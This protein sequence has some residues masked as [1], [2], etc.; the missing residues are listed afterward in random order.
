MRIGKFE[1]QAQNEL[2]FG[3][4]YLTPDAG[5]GINTI[6]PDKINLP[7]RQKILHTANLKSDRE[8]HMPANLPGFGSAPTENITYKHGEMPCTS[9]DKETQSALLNGIVPHGFKV[10]L[11][12]SAFTLC[13]VSPGL[14]EM[15]GY[16]PEGHT[17]LLQACKG[18]LAAL[19]V[20][21]DI[22]QVSNAWQE[23]G[24]AAAKYTCEYRLYCKNG[25]TLWVRESG[26]KSMDEQG[27]PVVS[28]VLVGINKYKNTQMQLDYERERS[29]IVLASSAE[30]IYEYQ[31]ENDHMVFY[32]SNLV[33]DEYELVCKHVPNWLE[34]LEQ[35]NIIH[36]DDIPAVRKFFTQSSYHTVEARF[37]NVR[38]TGEEYVWCLIHGTAVYGNG[39]LTKVIGDITNSSQARVRREDQEELREIFYDALSQ[40]YEN[41]CRINTITDTY[42]LYSSDGKPFRNVPNSGNYSTE[43]GYFIGKN[44]YEPDRPAYHRDM[45]IAS[46]MAVLDAGHPEADFSYRSLEADGSVRWKN[47]R[48]TYFHDNR[49]TILLTV[50]DVH[51]IRV[52][53]EREEYRLSALLRESCDY[54]ME[55]NLENGTCRQYMP[56]EQNRY[57]LPDHT[58]YAEFLHNYADHYVLPEECAYFLEQLE[59][60]TLIKHVKNR[61][62]NLDFTVLEADGSHSYKSW[63]SLLGRYEHQDYLLCYV[64]DVT[65]RVLELQEREHESEKN[66]NIIKDALR[67]AEQA[68]QAKTNF[69]S[70]MSHEIRTPMNAIIGMSEIMAASLDKRSAVED[71]LKKIT[72]SSHFLLSLINDILDMARIESGKL[73][74]VNQEFYLAAFLQ[75]IQSIIQP[76]TIDRGIDFRIVN[77]VPMQ[78]LVGDALRLKQVLLNLLSNALKFTPTGGKIRMVITVVQQSKGYVN[79]EFTVEDTGIG[80]APQRLERIFDPFEQADNDIAQRYGGTGLGLS[81][82]KSLVSLMNGYISVRSTPLEGS[83]FRVGLPMALCTTENIPPSENI[84][85]P[86]TQS[87]T[88]DF[89]GRRVLVVEDNELNM[90]ITR[91]LLEFKNTQVEEA[92]NGQQA[93]DMF[94]KSPPHYYDAVLMDMLMPVKDGLEATREIRASAHPNAQSIPILAMTANAFAQDMEA[95]R[96]SGMN[97]HLA[98]PIDTTRMYERLK[99]YFERKNS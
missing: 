53:Q 11:L 86:Q 57:P 69:L 24:N 84:V 14:C 71:C 87:S 52:A 68:S 91:T 5:I 90:E 20:P 25:S 43:V 27:R 97:E 89:T 81:I 59:L 78:Y 93:V 1:S 62:F 98:K 64:R 51:D 92:I 36:L 33:S 34:N 95:C 16:G 54:V 2:L 8:K 29:R 28:S 82:T 19:I 38:K 31:L 32:P 66:R 6:Y 30:M 40:D 39:V 88:I 18:Q 46:M 44:V 7:R 55:V 48:Y 79:L 67:A 13:S 80:I 61:S 37:R 10:N 23:M 77:K 26:E 56:A 72:S 49:H 99:Y 47:I 63:H 45:S 58:T 75:S 41:I 12:D 94:L 4:S 83:E 96:R 3:N 60:D 15:L 70:R 17:D 76:Q 73:V 50:R 22:A 35:N 65:G 9:A 74:I 21:E 42:K 85:Q